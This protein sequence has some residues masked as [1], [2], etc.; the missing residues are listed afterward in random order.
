MG[1]SHDIT[2][3]KRTEDLLK[4][5]HARLEERTAELSAALR[6]NE[7]LFSTV[8]D[9]INSTHLTQ[10]C[11][12]MM[13]H[14]IDLV[15]ADRILLYLVDH[16]R[17]EILL[18]LGSGSFERDVPMTYQELN[19][20]IA[21]QVFKSGQ[22]VLSLS[23][24]DEPP[25][26]YERRVRDNVGSLLL[27]PLLTR[28]GIGTLR[29]IGV[30]IVINDIGQPL[31]AELVRE[32]Q[33]L[34]ALNLN[35]PAAI[36]VLDN[37]RRILSSN[38]A[39]EKLYGYSHE[40]VIGIKLDTLITTPET[41]EEAK[42][43][44]QEALTNKVHA[45]SKRRRKD[46]SLVDVEIFGVPVLVGEGKVGAL[47]IYHDISEHVRARKEAEDASRSKSEFLANM[48]HEIRTP[49]NGVIGMLELALD[50]QLTDEQR[51]YL[52]TSLQSAEALLTLINDI[53]DFSKIEAGKIEIEAIDF[54]LRNAVED[55][56]Y[57]LAKRAQDKGLELACL[58]HPDLLADLH[59]DA[60]RLRQILVNLVGN[61]IKFTHQGEVV[62]SR[63]TSRRD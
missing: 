42:A 2:E 51:D 34:E 54:N 38:P 7:G 62:T 14:F 19:A 43:I 50:T 36:V 30:V 4:K 57:T 60:N 16:E 33:F 1:N 61:A 27:V 8:Q 6:E 10:I 20:G 32:K 52:Q 49:M 5:E 28:K 21:G 26:T 23:A 40:D 35:S 58:I 22:P 37:N 15:K 12:S 29:V 18:S 17:Q 56:A 63:G 24:D 59:G 44:T 11:Q 9:I 31:E 48:S 46:G 55:V 25:E 39:F 41:I 13:E 3:R 45:F 53:L 47:A